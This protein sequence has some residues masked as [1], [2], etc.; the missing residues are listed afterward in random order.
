MKAVKTTAEYTIFQKRNK[1]YCVQNAANKVVN[2]EEKTKILL[3]EGLI[4]LT[5]PAA[6]AEPE[7]PAEEAAEG[8]SEAAAE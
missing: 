3:A 1:R 6:P 2:G 7:A 4:K 8:D 5:A